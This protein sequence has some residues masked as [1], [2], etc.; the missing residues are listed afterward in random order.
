M[1]RALS[2]KAIQ[3]IK[4]WDKDVPDLTLE[5]DDGKWDGVDRRKSHSSCIDPVMDRRKECSK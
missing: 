2:N 5:K 3:E 4:R 1:E